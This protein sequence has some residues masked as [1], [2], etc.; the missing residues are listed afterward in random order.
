MAN[1]DQKIVIHDYRYNTMLHKH[2]EAKLRYREI[3]ALLKTIREQLL[4]D[5]HYRKPYLDHLL[6]T[7]DASS[8]T[9]SALAQILHPVR[10]TD[11]EVY[12]FLYSHWPQIWLSKTK[13][14]SKVITD[15]HTSTS[16]ESESS[17][18]YT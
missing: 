13:K 6:A 12:R 8:P 1:L 4:T 9:S 17:T 7:Y 11:A 16:E 3:T 5:V 15:N 14:E 10:P 2:L 18:E